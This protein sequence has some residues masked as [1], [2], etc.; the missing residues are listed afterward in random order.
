MTSVLQTHKWDAHRDAM[1]EFSRK[2]LDKAQIKR[3]REIEAEIKVNKDIKDNKQNEVEEKL[4]KQG[5]GTKPIEP[6][7]RS[8]RDAVRIRIIPQILT[9]N[10]TLLWLAMEAAINEWEWPQ[11]ITPEEFVDTYLYLS[12]KQRGITLGGYQVEEAKEEG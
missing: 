10:S 9:M 3:D 11:N 6:S 7:A 4:K 5:D 8:I 1:M 12:F 2:G